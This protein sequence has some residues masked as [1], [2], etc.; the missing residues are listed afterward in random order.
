MPV[1]QIFDTKEA[2]PEFLREHLT[3]DNGKFVFRAELPGDVGGL[4]SA[5]KAERDAKA[6]LEKSLKGFEG[7]DPAKA[8]ELLGQQQ[9]AEEEKAKA[10]GDWENWKAQMQKQH[11]TE[12][13]AL[14][15][16]LAQAEQDYEAEFVEAKVTAEIANAKGKARLLKSHVGAKSVVVD[17][18]REIRIYD[19]AGNVRYGKDGKPMTVAERIAEMQRDPEFMVAF[20]ASGAG[21]SGAQNNTSGGSG[22]SSKTLTRAQFEQLSPV[23]RQAHFKGGGKVVD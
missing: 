10:Q 13:Q 12:K 9:K 8:R 23:E 3:E 17:G 22:G 19:D 6:A 5:L 21:G 2:A 16:K 15:A 4:K 18:K 14:E 7:I 11:E 20:E 1:E